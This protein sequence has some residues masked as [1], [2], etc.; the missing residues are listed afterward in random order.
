MENVSLTYFLD[1]V[2]KAGTPKLTVVEDFKN[3]DKYDPRADFYK[4]LRE[5]LVDVQQSGGRVADLETWARGVHDRKQASYLAIV[6]G[7]KKFAGKRSFRWFDPPKAN[8][9]VGPL[10]INVNPELGLEIHGVPHVIKLHL[11]EDALSK[12]RAQIVLHLLEQALAAPATPRTFAVLDARKG[13]LHTI[14][15]PP[16]GIGALLA[17][18]AASFATMFAS[19]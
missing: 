14:G 15:A 11:K 19:L 9:V 3:R 18:E 8:H 17:G 10:T 5:K 6:A 4:A 16:R 7:Y 1:F 2:L 13:K 12:P